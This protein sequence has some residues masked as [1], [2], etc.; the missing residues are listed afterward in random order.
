LVGQG[1]SLVVIEVNQR[2]RRL[3]L[4]ESKARKRVRIRRLKELEE[5]QVLTGNVVNLAD[6]GAFVDLGGIDGL[7][8][9]S[10]LDHTHV[11]DPG[12]I[13]DV[14]DQVEVY[15]LN[16][17]AERKRVAL[18]RKRLQPDPW[19]S[20]ARDLQIGE[21]V[22]GSV[23]NVVDFGAFVDLGGGI[24]GLVHISNMPYGDMTL[25]ELEPGV[26]VDV[27]VQAI[28]EQ[29]RQVSLEL[30]RIL[31]PSLPEAEQPA[32]DV[33]ADAGSSAA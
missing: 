13:L 30:E 14:G 21:Q 3:I 16:V 10:E 11:E 5:G 25:E 20:A 28:D 8:H 19:A 15:V 12:D 18:S 4:S 32:T 9:I 2:R 1:L 31:S 29:R 24:D 6:F 26:S 33:D 27:R 22:R 7:I 17:D 23:T